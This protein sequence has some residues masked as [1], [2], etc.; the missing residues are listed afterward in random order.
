M[1]ITKLN[2]PFV[3]QTILTAA[4]LNNV[5]DKID[6]IIDNWPQTVNP[7][8]PDDDENDISEEIQNAKDW[9]SGKIEDLQALID[10]FEAGHTTQDD[11]NS[12]LN[13]FKGQNGKA[14]LQYYGLVDSD[15]HPFFNVLIDENGV[16]P[17]AIIAAITDNN[18]NLT[19][20]IGISADNI[21]LDGNVTL[22]GKLNAIQADISNINVPD[23]ASIKNAVINDIEAG[24][25][26]ITGTLNYNRLVGNVTTINLSGN[27]VI[28]DNATYIKIEGSPSG[29]FDTISFPVN[30]I[31]G[32]TIY[33]ESANGISVLPPNSQ[34]QNRALLAGWIYSHTQEVNIG[35]GSNTDTY[36]VYKWGLVEYDNN[37]KMY[38]MSP[39]LDYNL[40]GAAVHSYIYTG[41][42][43]VE[44]TALPERTVTLSYAQKQQYGL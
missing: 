44:T 28:P 39:I 17:A 20:Q 2:K 11:G 16:K 21:Q 43:W 14:A 38:N 27:H 37:I 42:R 41:S 26:T 10:Q 30:P 40:K 24:N 6:T 33:I 1:N 13:L 8:I 29:Y 31:E 15:G 12:F 3:A 23:T 35:E 4:Q 7:P 25:V 9:I 19:S 22:T 32:Q 34:V 18:G 5:T 36:Y